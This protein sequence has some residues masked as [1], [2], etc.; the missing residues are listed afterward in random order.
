MRVAS[1]LL[2]AAA[3]VLAFLTSWIFLP[4]PNRA[5]LTLG[6]GAPELPARDR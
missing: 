6:V 2:F 1:R 5:L 4:A 3:L